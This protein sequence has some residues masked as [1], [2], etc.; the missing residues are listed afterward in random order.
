MVA[1]END[2]PLFKK[3]EK[4]WSNLVKICNVSVLDDDMMDGFIKLSYAFGIFHGDDRG[5]NLLIKLF[6]LPN[7]SKKYSLQMQSFLNYFNPEFKDVLPNSIAIAKLKLIFIKN[8]Y[9]FLDDKNNMLEIYN[10]CKDG[11]YRLDSKKYLVN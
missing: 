7:I 10:L 1:L 6:S 5:Y 11:G 8:G 4:K 9:P 3:N 2:I